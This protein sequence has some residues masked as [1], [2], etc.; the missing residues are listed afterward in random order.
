M[1]NKISRSMLVV[2]CLLACF[3]YSPPNAQATAAN[4]SAQ[5]VTAYDLIVA[6]NTLRV[7]NGFPAL[8]EDPI[9]NAVAQATAQTMANSEMSWHIGNVRGRIQ[10]AGYGGGATVWATENFAVGTNIGIDFIMM[11]WADPD[12]MRPAVNPAYCHV[13]AGTARAPSGAIYY[14][15]QAAYTSTSS[16]G[17]YT[18]ESTTPNTEDN[19]NTGDTETTT[20][21]SQFIAPVKLATP[22]AEGKIYHEVA[23]GQSLWAIAV[24]YNLT[25]A[26]LEYWNNV[27]RTSG[28]QV[29]QRLFIPNKD[30]KGYVTPTPVGMVIVSPGD[31]T[32]K[33][34]HRV[35]AYQTLSTIADA[36]QV[37]VQDLLAF[38]GIQLDW[39]LRIGQQLVIDPGSNASPFAQLTPA[40]DGRYYHAIQE[41]E[42]LTSIATR[43]RIPLKDLIAWNDLTTSSTIYVGQKLYLA[44]TPIVP[45]TSTSP[46]NTATPT[47]TI[48]PTATPT[49]TELPP[50]DATSTP[51]PM[52]GET[53][54]Q[55]SGTTSLALLALGFVL[56]AAGMVWRRKSKSQ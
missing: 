44:V 45:P 18:T 43:Y 9:I 7:S 38:N 3:W 13:G 53:P 1:L 24:A 42:T 26:D 21:L 32:G 41:G 36:Y 25:I 23:F 14:V 56:G 16:C 48:I 39:P 31:D 55:P 20:P 15:L 51:T 2:L 49:S 4:T 8:I 27:S 46:P 34:V 6:M 28:I 54:V 33:V 40:S 19:S 30:T 37:P 29:G 17:S 50:Q 35:E 12:H 5:S 11:A 47:P 52:L 10:A 22:D